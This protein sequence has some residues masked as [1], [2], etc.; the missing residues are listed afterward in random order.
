MTVHV[1]RSGWPR[2]V[3]HDTA[4]SG[5]PIITYLAVRKAV[6]ATKWRPA[7]RFGQARRDSIVYRVEF[8]P[9]RDTLPLGL[10]EEYVGGN[11]ALPLRCPRPRAAHHVIVCAVP[12]RVR[13]RV[14]Y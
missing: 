7:R 4:S 5:I 6:L 9:L 13:S 2:L 14:I 11:S 1:E 3:R 8:V 12:D 10:H